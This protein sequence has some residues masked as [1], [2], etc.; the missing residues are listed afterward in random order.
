MKSSIYLSTLLQTVAFIA[1]IIKQ[2]YAQ[3]SSDVCRGAYVSQCNSII[4]ITNSGA[5]ITPTGVAPYT[6][7]SGTGEVAN[8]I[9][10]I[11]IVNNSSQLINKISTTGLH[12]STISQNTD[13]LDLTLNISIEPGQSLA[14]NAYNVDLAS[15]NQ[16]AKGFSCSSAISNSMSFTSTENN[17]RLGAYFTPNSGTSLAQTASACGFVGFNWQQTVTFDNINQLSSTKNPGVPLTSPYSDPPPSGY[18]TEDNPL[19]DSYPFYFNLE[20]DSSNWFSVANHELSF[21]GKISRLEFEDRPKFDNILSGQHFDLT[22]QLVGVFANSA[23]KGTYQPLGISFNWSSNY[24]QQRNTG[25]VNCD[26]LYNPFFDPGPQHIS[27]ME[28]SS[29][30][31]ITNYSY[32]G[33]YTI[34]SINDILTGPGFENDFIAQ[35][36]EPSQWVGSILCSFFTFHLLKKYKKNLK[37]SK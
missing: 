20:R 13:P 30:S 5:T 27:T 8:Y 31:Y 19:K 16:V 3:A 26:C 23:T 22:T 33:G 18:S 11:G 14:V 15:A 34:T 25:G 2:D 1:M 4:N 24:D 7:Y 6:E 12:Y 28:Q 21:N 17:T 10:S 35:V 32:D 36:P 37:C 9:N 29:L